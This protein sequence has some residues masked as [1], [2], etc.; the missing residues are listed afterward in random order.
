MSK[1]K[2][3]PKEK[4][5]MALSLEK[6]ASK[7][8][9]PIM[10]TMINLA[11]THYPAIRAQYTQGLISQLQF[12]SAVISELSS[13]ENYNAYIDEAPA[14]STTYTPIHLCHKL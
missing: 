7:L 2:A 10:F 4:Y 1:V 14:S 11:S 9:E 6:Q 12:I 8:L 13:S 5:E 3:T